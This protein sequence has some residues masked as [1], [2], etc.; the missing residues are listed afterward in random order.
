MVRALVVQSREGVHIHLHSIPF[1][2]FKEETLAGHTVPVV[3]V[4]VL[5]VD[6]PSLFP[7][8]AK[9]H[10]D[11]LHILATKGEAEEVAARNDCSEDARFWV[12]ST[13]HAC[14]VSSTIK[15][16]KIISGANYLQ[17]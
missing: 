15:I 10:K 7:V 6:C 1:L 3:V 8:L 2:Q 12:H 16:L 11:F 4:V 5:V 17:W 9:S 14:A 13:S